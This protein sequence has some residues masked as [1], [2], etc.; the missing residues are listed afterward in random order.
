M[1]VNLEVIYFP[2]HLNDIITDVHLR[3]WFMSYGIYIFQRIC[4]VEM[5]IASKHGNSTR[6]EKKNKK[7]KIEIY[8]FVIVRID[9][10]TSSG[11][12]LT[13]VQFSVFT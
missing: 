11:K 2:I 8:Y 5:K 6:I 9:S 12:S 1:Y 7:K 13:D 10:R 4:L 3:S